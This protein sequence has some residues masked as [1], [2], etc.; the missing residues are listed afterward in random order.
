MINL[1]NIVFDLGGVLIDFKPEIFLEKLGYNIEEVEYFSTLNTLVI[2]K[3]FLT[4]LTI[5]IFYSK[6]EIQPNI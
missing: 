6:L 1:K 5:I 3:R 2:S 4:A